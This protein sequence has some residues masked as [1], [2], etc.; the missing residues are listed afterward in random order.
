MLLKTKPERLIALQNISKGCCKSSK[1]LNKQAI[2]ITKPRKH[3]NSVILIGAGKSLTALILLAGTD[4]PSA[5][6]TYP[7]NLTFFKYK[8]YFNS[9]K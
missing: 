8:A 2:I 7:R 6:T 3:Y 5:D 4:T 1:L 9:L